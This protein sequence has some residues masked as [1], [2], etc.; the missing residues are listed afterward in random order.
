MH[1]RAKLEERKQQNGMSNGK[2]NA[3]SDTS[4]GMLAV[5]LVVPGGPGDGQLSAGDVLVQINGIVVT[6]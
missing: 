1:V 4:T 2:E 3:I 6:T 5:D